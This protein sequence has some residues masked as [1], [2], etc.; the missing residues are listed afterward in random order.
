[1]QS[2]KHASNKV[3]LTSTSCPFFRV[4]TAVKHKNDIMQTQNGPRLP[5]DP[6]LPSLPCVWEIL[7]NW[8]EHILCHRPPHTSPGCFQ[9][10]C[11]DRQEGDSPPTFLPLML[12]C[13]AE[14]MHKH[15]VGTLRSE[16]DLEC[17]HS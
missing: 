14:A 17:P 12:L 4:D 15:T 8:G 11:G 13:N 1:M 5:Q 10:P 16:D 2:A 6:A 9:A 3:V 7:C